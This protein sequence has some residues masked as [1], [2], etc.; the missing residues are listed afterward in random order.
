MLR[1]GGAAE[2][3]SKGGIRLGEIPREELA[4]AEDALVHLAERAAGEREEG[5]AEPRRSTGACTGSK[6]VSER[7]QTR[8]ELSLGHVAHAFRDLRIFLEG[9]R[10]R[11]GHHGTRAVVERVPLRREQTERATGIAELP[12]RV[13]RV[14]TGSRLREP[15][16]VVIVWLLKQPLDVPLRLAL[17][18]A[19]GSPSRE[20]GHR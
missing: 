9:G 20:Q 6:A 19:L 7:A 1:E 14:S 10:Q 3:V 16:H 15:P 18:L 12:T 5:L 13:I 2:K 17:K 11:M 4:S 8:V